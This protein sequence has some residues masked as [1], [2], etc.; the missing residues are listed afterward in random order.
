M[1]IVFSE[2]N[3][4]YENYVFPYH[5]WGL[6]CD[7]ENTSSIYE[8]GFLPI[9][10]S[11]NGV[12]YLSRSSRVSVEQFSETSE[13]RRVKNKFITV[14]AELLKKED[15]ENEDLFFEIAQSYSHTKFGSKTFSSQR[16]QKLLQNC[17]FNYRI[18]FKQEDEIIGFVVG[19][20]DEDI[21]HYAYSF[22]KPDLIN[23]SF[24]IYMMLN[25]ITYLKE[26]KIK[27]VYL[28]TCYTKSSLYKTNF[29]GFEFFNGFRWSSNLKELKFIID[30]K[31]ENDHLMSQTD[32]KQ[33]FL[34][35]ESVFD[36]ITDKFL[37]MKFE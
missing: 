29:K 26:Q 19:M 23:S 5:I 9:S 17:Y 35:N 25:S 7:Y 10:N 15:I 28:G 16:I 18:V 20:L 36:F 34:N 3:P 4:D 13:N 33:K 1:R 32:F 27:Y 2:T 8:M 12:Y 6:K 21:F 24:G 14:T 22:Y 31:I 37:N 11:T 30:T